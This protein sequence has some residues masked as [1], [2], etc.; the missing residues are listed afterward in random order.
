MIKEGVPNEE[1]HSS[2]GFSRSTAWNVLK[3]C[4][5]KVNHDKRFPTRPTSALIV[6]NGFHMATLEPHLFEKE[7]EV[8]PSQIDG[9]SPLTKHYKE[10]FS[11]MQE[12]DE[13]ITWLSR[14]EFEMVSD[15]ADSTNSHPWFSSMM[16]SGN[17]IIEGS[18][19]FEF[20]GVQ[21][22]VRPDLYD[23]ESGLIID[24]KSTQD[25]SES[26]FRSSVRKW[27]YDFQVAWY[28]EGLRQMGHKV[29]DFVFVAVEK[30]SP[31]LVAC[32][33]IAPNFIEQQKRQMIKACQIWAN[34]KAT[35]TFPGY[36]TEVVTL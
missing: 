18:G 27:G 29:T 1:Y 13:S 20:E 2:E 4:P 8:K 9:K 28:M 36:S 3:T 31:H 32:Y 24:L 25:A 15:M 5:E 17:F 34:C 14:S 30:S 16:E 10:K 19:Y 12:S 22:K 33:R 6:G 26:G 21:C 11:E 35:K 23:P 7:Y